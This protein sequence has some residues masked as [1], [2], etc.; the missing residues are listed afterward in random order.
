MDPCTRIS[1][2]LVGSALTT[3]SEV[4]ADGDGEFPLLQ[5]VRKSPVAARAAKRNMKIFYCSCCYTFLVRP[6]TLQMLP[7]IPRV[8]DK[9]WVI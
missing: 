5:H 7:L 9:I 8:L 2:V 4:T 6:K 1:G 3:F